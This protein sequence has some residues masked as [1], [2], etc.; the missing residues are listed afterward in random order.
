MCGICGY[1]GL[2]EDGLLSRMMDALTH[3][4]P[5]GDGTYTAGDVG[6]GH[7][8]LSIIDVDGGRQPLFNEDQTLALV[9]NGEIYNYRELRQELLSRGHM[10]RT[11]SDSEV[12]LHLYE[13]KGP[14]CV[15]DLTGMFA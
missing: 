1:V 6:L 8:R 15:R 13:E 12:I 7:R 5:D 4:G 9:C 14:E 2:T 10:F 3:R 11:R